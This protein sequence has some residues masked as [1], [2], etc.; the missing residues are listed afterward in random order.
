MQTSARTPAGL[1]DADMLMTSRDCSW[2]GSEAAM[3]GEIRYTTGNKAYLVPGHL[4]GWAILAK[5]APVQEAWEAQQFQ[6]LWIRHISVQAH[7]HMQPCKVLRRPWQSTEMSQP[8]QR[9]SAK[10]RQNACPLPV[11][12][13]RAHIEHLR[14]ASRAGLLSSCPPK[15]LAL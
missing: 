9:S 5:G 1:H 10:G 8:L 12:R 14:A 6:G 2:L 4:S 11:V 3:V 13:L 7:V 15:L